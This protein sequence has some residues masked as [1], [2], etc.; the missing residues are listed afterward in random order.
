MHVYL[1]KGNEMN[2]KTT[3]E[4]MQAVLKCKKIG[5]AAAIY[6]VQAIANEFESKFQDEIK[7]IRD[8][9]SETTK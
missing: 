3:I 2:Q 1:E 5:Q 9:E 4:A 8:E 6:A 7:R